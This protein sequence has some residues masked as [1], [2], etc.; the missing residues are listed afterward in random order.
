MAVLGGQ[1]R[2]QG[3]LGFPPA[4]LGL[5][6]LR[7]GVRDGHWRQCWLPAVPLSRVLLQISELIVRLG[8][9]CLM[10]AVKAGGGKVT[11]TSHLLQ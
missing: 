5:G 7:Q 10:S 3:C 2:A 6:K 1:Q 9:V 4:S 11:D 8:T